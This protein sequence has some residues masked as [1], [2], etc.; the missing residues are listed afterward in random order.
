VILE[1][2]RLKVAHL[3]ASN[4]GVAWRGVEDL[5]LCCLSAFTRLGSFLIVELSVLVSIG[6]CQVCVA[7]VVHYPLSFVTFRN[8]RCSEMLPRP[9]YVIRNI[10]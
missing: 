9:T 10:E 5:V 6:F 4:R 8:F 7:D 2:N 3:A 1:S